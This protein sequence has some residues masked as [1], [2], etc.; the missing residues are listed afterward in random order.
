MHPVA[1]SLLGLEDLIV[2]PTLMRFV[3]KEMHLVEFVTYMF[4][5]IRLVPPPELIQLLVMLKSKHRKRWPAGKEKAT[6][7]CGKMSMLIWPPML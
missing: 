6:A 7:H 2:V 4:Q 5:A 1:N 3:T